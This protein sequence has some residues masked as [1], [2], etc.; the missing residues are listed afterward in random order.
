MDQPSH[1]YGS[2]GTNRH[3]RFRGEAALERAG[4][5]QDGFAVAN[6]TPLLGTTSLDLRLISHVWG[7]I[8]F[9]RFKR[10]L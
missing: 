4:P 9:W 5:P 2:A 10:N 8:T 3:E 6:L 7:I 1:R